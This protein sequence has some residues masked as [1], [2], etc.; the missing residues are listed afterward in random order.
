MIEKQTNIMISFFSL[1]LNNLHIDYLVV[2]KP[3]RKKC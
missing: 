1:H 3:G 2:Q